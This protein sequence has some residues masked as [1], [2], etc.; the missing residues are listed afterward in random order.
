MIEVQPL[1]Q[2]FSHRLLQVE[3]CVPPAGA[4]AEGGTTSAAACAG[5]PA[6]GWAWDAMGTDHSRR[7][8]RVCH[9]LCHQLCRQ[10][11][12]QLRVCVEV[13]VGGGGCSDILLWALSSHLAQPSPWPACTVLPCVQRRVCWLCVCRVAVLLTTSAHL[14]TC[15][16]TYTRLQ[17]CSRLHAYVSPCPMDSW[18]DSCRISLSDLPCCPC[19]PRRRRPTTSSAR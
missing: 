4:A 13:V 1:Q 11:L 7:H 16:A 15:E 6:G 8:S 14:H 3:P 18:Y 9:Q 5:A 2:L 12:Q 17:M 10:L 19:C